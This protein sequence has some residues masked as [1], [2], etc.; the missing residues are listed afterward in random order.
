MTENFIKEN[1]I[2]YIKNANLKKHNT[3]RIN[4]T[5]DYLIYPKDKY[6]LLKILK[7]IK[8]NELKYMILGNGSNIILSKKHY[9]GII[10]KLDNLNNLERKRNILTIEAGY[11]LIKL[12]META[13]MGLSGLEFA[14]GIP[15]NV[16]AS[17]AM[18][19]GAYNN[20]ISEV[21][22]SVEVI[23]DNFELKTL[24][25][26]ELD[27]KYRD[28]IFKHKENY[29]IVSCKLKLKPTK[30]EKIIDLI[31]TRSKKRRETQPLD[32]P[33]AGSVFR[34][35]EG[36]HSGELIEKCGLKGYQIGG[37]KVSEKHAN[38]IIN[39]NN[40]TGEDIIKLID[41]IKEKVKEKYNIE[42]VL[43]Q[44]IVD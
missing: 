25:A 16:G 2:K 7:Y 14:G 4:A 19:A 6:E 20:S 12:A 18:N 43:E 36:M 1:N 5:C 42:L 30:K 10:I 44:I 23:T 17:I 33:S 13:I 24:K 39:Y 31:K 8:N 9:D 41:Y 34:N 15:G 32:Y 21:V 29:I 35:P 26:N 28:S 37:A 11:S 3:Y 22:D 27:F 40:A 38:F